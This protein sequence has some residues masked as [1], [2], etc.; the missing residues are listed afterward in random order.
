IGITL[1][2]EGRG[3]LSDRSRAATL[4]NLLVPYAGHNAVS[5]GDAVVC[6]GPVSRILGLLTGPLERWAQAAQHFE[7][8]LTMARRMG[9]R[10]LLA[11]GQGAYAGMLL[12]CPDPDSTPRVR[13]LLNEALDAVQE[14]GMKG[15]EEKV[16]ALR[17]RVP[18]AVPLLRRRGED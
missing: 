11:R 14:L 1:V 5:G 3:F 4:Y 13:D 17:R 2:G 9:A 15:L 12:A 18:P 7:A 16:L 8:A 6:T 10:A